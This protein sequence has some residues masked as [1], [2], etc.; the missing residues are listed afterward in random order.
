MISLTEE[1]SFEP[2]F[3]EAEAHLK[4]VP[5]AL[6][7]SYGWGGGAWMQAWV[8]RTKGVGAKLF[9]NGLAIENAPDADGIAKCEA[10]G[11]ASST[12]FKQFTFSEPSK[13]T[14]RKKHANT[15]ES[16]GIHVL[17]NGYPT[18]SVAIS[19]KMTYSTFFMPQI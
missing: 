11:L 13:S 3:S 12:R 4:D 1:G 18:E 14:S 16:P 7:G 8:E 10:L 15:P 6:F 9:G 5:V 19:L 2:F 17:R